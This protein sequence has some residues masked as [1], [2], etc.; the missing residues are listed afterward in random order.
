MASQ[1]TVHSRATP[2][3]IVVVGGG[4][5]GAALARAL[6]G[7]AIALVAPQR[8]PAPGDGFDSRVYAISPGNARFLAELQAWQRLPQA[9]LT[10][11]H[12][13]RVYGD[14]ARAMLE[15]DAYAAGVPELAWIVEDGRLQVALRHGLE[16]QDRLER[17]DGAACER[18]DVGASHAAVVLSDGRRLEARLVVGADGAQSR[19]R[20]QAGLAIDVRGYG[21]RAVVANFA[22]ERAHGNVALQWFQGGPVLALLPL[23][24]NHVSMV[25]SMQEAEAER[26]LDLAPAELA[27]EVRSA[28][29]NALGELA[30]VTPARAF[31]LQRMMAQRIVAPRVALAG[32]AA[33]VV[34]PL[35]GQGANL[36]FHDARELARTLAAREPERDPGDLRLLRRYE[37]ARAEDILAMRA[38]V[39]GLFR[40]FEARGAAPAWLRNAGLGA[41][42]R[43]AAIKNL[44]MRRAMS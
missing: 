33:H 36:G 7:A 1:S 2:F 19:V 30:V 32:D 13:M 41:V 35:A 22:C 31:P 9:C 43:L 5:V 14:D 3:D 21:Q 44:L 25:W 4:L 8:A 10:P 28:S 26:L 18:L 37:R 12:A 11:V 24:G 23:P 34:H 39:H 6:R 29:R 16:T 40:L 38:T 42:N 17:F 15:L 20:E 27:R